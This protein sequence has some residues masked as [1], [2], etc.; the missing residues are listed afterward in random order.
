M[1]NLN[2]V[3]VAVAAFSGGLLSSVLGWLDSKEP[4]DSRKFGRSAGFALLS[5][6]GFAVGYSFSNSIGARDVFV[7]ILA[8]AG[9]D[10]IS[11]RAIG[12][13]RRPL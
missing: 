8:G 1:E 13:L 3:V 5:G 9:V 7:A 4:W 10:S 11:N 2:L 6:I 12:A